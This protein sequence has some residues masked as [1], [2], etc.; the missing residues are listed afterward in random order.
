[1]QALSR[2]DIELFSR[3]L[4]RARKISVVS[5]THPDGDAAGSTAALLSYI[6]ECRGKDVKVILPDYP[7]ETLLFLCDG[8]IFASDHAVEAEEWISSSDLIILIDANEFRRT[9]QLEG[10]LRASSAE[11]ILIDHHVGP[12]R[13]CFSTVFSETEISSACE[14]L[15]WILME[16]PD[17]NADAARLPGAAAMALMAGMTTDTNNFANSVFPSTMEMAS[18]LLQ[19]GVDRDDILD[20][21]Y[22][23]YRE[24]RVRA[25]GYLQSECMRITPKGAA[26]MI[27][28]RDIQKRFDMREGETEGLV[29]V[30]LVIGKVR[31]SLFL[32]EDDGYFRVSIRSKEG[33]SARELAKSRFHGGGHEKA[34]GGKLYF[35]G[36][37]PSPAD[38]AA[39][40]ESATEEFLK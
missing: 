3:S 33:T 28:T 39:Y 19:A 10:I 29:N 35:P 12:D 16:M 1:M 24:N 14:L 8:V 38:A 37:I 9:E 7:S 5:H 27:A 20:H 13:E 40:I 18:R 4:D 31:M 11:K 17:I 34:A 22:F 32:K 36:D 15:F 6:R 2:A 30:P 23:R 25:M 21:I 26:Y